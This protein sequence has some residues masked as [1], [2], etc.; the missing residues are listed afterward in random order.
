MRLSSLSH[1][2][3]FKIPGTN[4]VRIFICNTNGFSMCQNMDGET[5]FLSPEL[6]VMTEKSW[7][8]TAGGIECHTSYNEMVAI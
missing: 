4:Q 6:E 2:D 8:Y 3:R 1:G 7:P 5:E